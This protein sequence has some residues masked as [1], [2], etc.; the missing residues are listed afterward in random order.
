MHYNVDMMYMEK[1]QNEFD[2]VIDTMFNMDVMCK[3][4]FIDMKMMF[5]KWD[6]N[7]IHKTPTRAGHLPPAYFTMTLKDMDDIFIYTTI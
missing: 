6:L 2:N 4:N 5:K 1:I 7:Y 3:D